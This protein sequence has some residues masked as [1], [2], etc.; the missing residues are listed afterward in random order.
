MRT[1]VRRCLLGACLLW[2]GRATVPDEAVAQQG[3][4]AGVVTDE[5]TGDP[6]EAA[7][8]ILTGPNRIET[9]NREGRFVF[10]NVAPGNYQV[11]VLRLGYRP[12]ADSASVAAGETVALAFVLAPA[13][14]QL[15]EVVSTATGQQ[16]R[17]EIGNS[18]ST[19]DASK[20]AQEAPITEFGNLLTGRAA[21][22]Q[23]LKSSG[24]TGTGTK[25][26]IRGSNS[27]SL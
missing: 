7:R 25:I 12:R 14:V 17:L 20:I 2:A 11:R 26:R 4:I 9:T 27:V 19:I 16:S 22:V 15:D 1:E 18:V 13:P 10:R 21:G 23:V 3:A 8:V 6:L 24:A 5:A